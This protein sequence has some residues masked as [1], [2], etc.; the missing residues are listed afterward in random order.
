MV[1]KRKPVKKKGKDGWF[2]VKLDI[3]F[4]KH[5]SGASLPTVLET[6]DVYIVCIRVLISNCWIE[7][8]C[9]VYP[10]IS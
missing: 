10:L 9:H 7:M 8:I 2:Y 4:L 5:H 3:F 1:G 6:A